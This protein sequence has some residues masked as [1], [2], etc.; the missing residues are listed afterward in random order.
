MPLVDAAS[1]LGYRIRKRYRLSALLRQRVNSWSFLA[2]DMQAG[3]RQVVVRLLDTTARDSAQFARNGPLDRLR[4]LR[5]GNLSSYEDIGPASVEVK[6]LTADVLCIVRPFGSQTLSAITETRQLPEEDIWEVFRA[7]LQALSYL[8]SQGALH[9]DLRP[10]N[11]VVDDG[12]YRLVDYYLS[13]VNLFPGDS[14]EPE[15]WSY[16]A[17]EVFTNGATAASDVFSFGAMVQQLATSNGAAHRPR[18]G[19]DD[20]GQLARRTTRARLVP[21]LEMCRQV[22]PGRRPD[23]ATLIDVL[24][25]GARRTVAAVLGAAGQPH[26]LEL[27]MIQLRRRLS[28]VGR[29]LSE[30]DVTPL[31]NRA[32][33]G[34]ARE[35]DAYPESSIRLLDLDLLA[36]HLATRAL[37][38]AEDVTY[39]ERQQPTLSYLKRYDIDRATLPPDVDDAWLETMYGRYERVL[40]ESSQVLDTYP[41]LPDTDKRRVQPSTLDVLQ[42]FKDEVKIASRARAEILGEPFLFA[43]EVV[44]LLGVSSPGIGEGEVLALREKGPLLAVEDHERLVFPAFQF[45]L[46]RAAPYPVVAR[47]GTILAAA[48]SSWGVVSWWMRPHQYL[49]GVTPKDLL[50]EASREDDILMA[51]LLS[52]GQ[53]TAD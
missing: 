12:S 13:A 45:D 46:E 37:E 41:F 17:P 38:S 44:G 19:T 10:Q 18:P 35:L 4:G 33:D 32:L 31:L 6:S 48:T 21:V 16:F 22:D 51:A 15:L 26:S 28:S 25:S 34:L 47:V 14:A 24:F 50:P 5:H 29:H 1:L 7:A 42:R 36:H 27:A 40:A 49:E 39:I 20:L 23:V 9:G 53:S 11:I 2:D 52:A 3:A 43:E 30:D 8:H